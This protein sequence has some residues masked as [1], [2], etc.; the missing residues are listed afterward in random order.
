MAGL[1]AV[2]MMVAGCGSSDTPGTSGSDSTSATSAAA[3]GKVGVILP[4][5]ASSARWET[6]DRPFLEEAF[7]TA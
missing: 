7:K 3:K 4:D 5:T 2:A 1:S 6:A